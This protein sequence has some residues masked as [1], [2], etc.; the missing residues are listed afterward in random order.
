MAGIKR[1]ATDKLFSDTI[2][3]AS[4]YVCAKCEQNFRHD[5]GMFDCSHV[6]SRQYVS[7]RYFEKNALALCR[8][9]HSKMASSPAEH[10]ELYK[11]V[12]GEDDYQ[13]L[14]DH[15]NRT[16]IR[17]R[18]AD[19]LAI[20]KHWKGELERMHLMRMQGVQGPIKLIGYRYG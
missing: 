8:S 2:R 19:K 16:D 11:R 9:C 10:I 4:D 3:E 13:A 14:L 18:K 6:K 5:P 12:R 17:L 15:Y 20:R 7:C 1:D